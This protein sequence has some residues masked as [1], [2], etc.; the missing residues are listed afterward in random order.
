MPE[1][2]SLKFPNRNGA[3]VERH[4]EFPV[5]RR[6]KFR[7]FDTR[8]PACSGT[9]MEKREKESRPSAYNA[10]RDSPESHRGRSIIFRETDFEASPKHFCAGFL[11]ED[12]VN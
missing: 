1:A 8:Q 5:S 9:K 7:G 12:N 10:F 2:D 3:Y 11:A 4:L 6:R